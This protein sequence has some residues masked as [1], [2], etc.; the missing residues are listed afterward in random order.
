MLRG[1]SSAGATTGGT[2]PQFSNLPT[3][4]GGT[5]APGQFASEPM[6][7]ALACRL[8]LADLTSHL[9]SCLKEFLQHRPARDSGAQW[10]LAASIAQAWIH[11]RDVL[12]QSGNPSGLSDSQRT[13]LALPSLADLPAV[14]AYVARLDDLA[15]ATRKSNPKPADGPDRL[16][17]SRHRAEREIAQANRLTLL[18]L[19]EGLH[20][21]MQAMQAIHPLLMHQQAQSGGTGELRSERELDARLSNLTDQLN[22]LIVIMNRD[23]GAMAAIPIALQ[24]RL[25]RGISACRTAERL[26]VPMLAELFE[27]IGALRHTTESVLDFPR[28]QAEAPTMAGYGWE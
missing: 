26:T 19:S 10:Q 25:G 16:S 3:A 18:A 8:D 6:P 28:P 22:H 2:H 13:A 21:L 20:G 12:A 24:Q 17:P 23:S 14:E 1:T 11:V 27:S 15:S 9:S 4:A 7:S 5:A